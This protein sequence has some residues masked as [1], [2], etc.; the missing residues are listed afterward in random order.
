MT[1]TIKTLTGGCHCGAIRYTAELDLSNLTAQKCNCTICQKTNRLGISVDPE[2][3]KVTTPS[4]LDQVP[5]YQ[6]GPKRQHFHFCT[7]CGVHCFAYGS[8]EYE[9]KTHKNFSINAVSLDP[10]QGVDLR[11]IKVGYWDGKAE[12]WAAGQAEKPYPGGYY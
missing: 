12:N 2:K 7:T 6:F 1:S 8:Y 5:E 11:E 9:G 10:D 4:S 3:F